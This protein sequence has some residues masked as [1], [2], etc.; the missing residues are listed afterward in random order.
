MKPVNFGFGFVFFYDVQTDNRFGCD[1]ACCR[2]V[3]QGFHRWVHLGRP[4]ER[5]HLYRRGVLQRLPPRRGDR[6]RGD[7]ILVVPLNLG[8]GGGDVMVLSLCIDDAS[9]AYNDLVLYG[10]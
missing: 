5:D 3:R 4:P 10:K 6:P 1:C 8:G 9:Y 7:D 2:A